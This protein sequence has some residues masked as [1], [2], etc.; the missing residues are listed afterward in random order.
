MSLLSESAKIDI[1]SL[2][3]QF[4]RIRD[5]H[6]IKCSKTYTFFF[7][8]SSPYSMCLDPQ[9]PYG[10]YELLLKELKEFVNLK[11]KPDYLV[12]RFSK[13]FPKIKRIK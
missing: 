8:Y 6:Y 9:R 2:T 13:Y 12:E 10:H 3:K 11:E 1:K 4:G 5:I 7:Y